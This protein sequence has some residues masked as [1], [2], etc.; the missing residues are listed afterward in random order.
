[1]Y[2]RLRAAAS[3]VLIPVALWLGLRWLLPLSFPFLLGTGLALLA[4][5]VVSLL[6]RKLRLPRPLAAGIGVSI[7]FCA[8]TALLALMLAFLLREL[9]L[10]SGI[11]PDLESAALSGIRLLQT[12]LLELSGRAPEALRSTLRQSITELFSGGTALVNRA[13][14]YL[15]G[16][17]G[18]VLRHVPDGALTLGT[19]V[20]SGFMI[21]AKLPRL[22]LWVRARLGSPRTQAARETVR[23]LRQALGGWLLAQLKLAGVTLGILLG[24]FILLKIPFAPL[25]ALGVS[26]V[27]AFPILGTGTVLLP[28]ALICYLRGDAARAIG[29]A[30]VYAVICT[31]RSVLE[32]RLLGRQLG[33]DPLVTLGAMYAGYKLWGLWGMILSPVLAVTA[34]QLRGTKSA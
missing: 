17:A 14:G 9:G 15:L 31:V 26:L 21:S 23:R 10:L 32:P 28:W 19:G 29:L 12:W 8:I 34:L 18:S 33:L 27:D 4:E 2:S 1:M 20:I 7:A 6:C 3:L 5:P 13:A 11:L 30:G 22:R 16:L 25:W 24:G